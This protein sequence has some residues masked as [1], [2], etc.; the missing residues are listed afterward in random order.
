MKK[1][2][3]TI[4]IEINN[5]CNLSCIMCMIK[6]RPKPFM[7][8][9]LFKKILSDWQE[10]GRCFDL[11]MPFFRGEPLL[12][13]Q[14]IE[15]LR[16]F[17]EKNKDYTLAKSIAFDTNA[18]LLDKDLSDIILT[19]RQFSTITFSIDAIKE[20]TYENIRKG[21]NLNKVIKNIKDFIQLR[22]E[23]GF[24]FPKI[25]LQFIVMPEN[26]NEAKEFLN[27]WKSYFKEINIILDII[28]E[29]DT[30][31]NSNDC[32]FFRPC[33]SYDKEKQSNDKRLYEQLYLDI[34]GNRPLFKDLP[35]ICSG[36]FSHIVI[37]SDG[38]VLPCCVDN[39]DRLTIGDVK[40]QKLV[41][42]MNGSSLKK[43][44]RLHLSMN[45]SKIDVCRDC[46]GQF[47][48]VIDES[49]LKELID[50]YE[51]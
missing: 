34:K 1:I 46:P 10:S 2:L 41:K 12:H 35:D 17:F 27:F 24:S 4:M 44:L 51:N 13:P 19:S 30:S 43:L 37:T 20:N 22:K 29:Y 33:M 14:F 6:N 28:F 48:P 15:F 38:L 47:F 3:Q 31:E 40:E 32:I 8:F 26:I 42:I 39:Q 23:Y 36:P 7:E 45:K 49:I 16:L 9:S 21:G 11:F 18:N 5:S 50:K 25:R